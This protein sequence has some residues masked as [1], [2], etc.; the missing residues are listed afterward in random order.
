MNINAMDTDIHPFFPLQSVAV[1]VDDGSI[2]ERGGLF[3]CSRN[4]R[5]QIEM[6]RIAS[7]THSERKKGEKQNERIFHK[8]LS[9]AQFWVGRIEVWKVTIAHCFQSG[10][11]YVTLYSSVHFKNTHGDVRLKEKISAKCG[12]WPLFCWLGPAPAA[13]F[14]PMPVRLNVRVPVQGW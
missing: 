8:L 12:S 5:T 13:A 11:K 9:W 2:T 6:L 1:W 10:K 4:P 14:W 7:K 3:Y